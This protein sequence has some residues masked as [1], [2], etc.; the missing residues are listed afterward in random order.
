MTAGG[1]PIPTLT[2]ERLVL[3]APVAAD[4]PA[5]AALLASS[6][7]AYMGGPFDR[8]AAWGVFC[9]GV[10]CWELF[11]HGSLMVDLRDGGACVGEVG[12]NAGPLFPERELGWMLYEGYEGRGYATEAVGTMRDWAARTLGL[13]GLVSYVDPENARSA[14]VARRLGAVLDPGAARQDPDD[15]VFRHPA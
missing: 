15:L 9:H 6:R 3:R 12:I 14:A 11:G 7:A 8:R 5:Y 1:F 10:A 2:T 4:F 13:T